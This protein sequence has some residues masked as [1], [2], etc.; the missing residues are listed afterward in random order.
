M[1]E[2]DHFAEACAGSGPGFAFG[3]SD[4]A[5]VI[6]HQ[7]FPERGEWLPL[8]LQIGCDYGDGQFVDFL[9]PN[10]I[11]QV[12]AEDQMIPP[13]VGTSVAPRTPGMA[14]LGVPFQ[15]AAPGTP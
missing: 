14:P 5:S 7:Y 9:D 11:L 4:P 2:V 15:N 12:S 3:P 1:V 8:E 13:E 10:M 6:W